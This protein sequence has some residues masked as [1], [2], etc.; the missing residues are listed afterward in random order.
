MKLAQDAVPKIFGKINPPPG[1]GA[2]CADPITGLGTFFGVILNLVFIVFGLLLFTYAVWGAMD[3][4]VSEGDKEKLSKAQAKITNAVMGLLV[5]VI[6]F[7]IFAIISGDVLGIL[8]RTPA[9]WQFN[10]PTLEQTSSEPPTNN[11]PACPGTCMN[12]SRCKALGGTT[13]GNYACET[14]CSN[15][16]DC[17]CCSGL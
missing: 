14:I 9:G 1:C 11:K 10:I 2:L 12:E 15:P 17:T 13:S 5:L 7:T 4:V 6:V 8:K 16:S 3:W